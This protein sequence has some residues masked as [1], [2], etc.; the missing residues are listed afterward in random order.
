MVTTRSGRR[1]RRSPA[2]GRRGRHPKRYRPNDHAHRHRIKDK[3]RKTEKVRAYI[4]R[5]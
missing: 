1:I 2:L 3:Q 4:R 5:I